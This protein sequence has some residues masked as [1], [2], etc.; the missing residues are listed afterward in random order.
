LIEQIK[1]TV[2]AS[3]TST[4]TNLTPTTEQAAAGADAIIADQPKFALGGINRRGLAIVPT[5]TEVILGC[6]YFCY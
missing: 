4:Y 5:F 3:V 2:R 6:F 1:K